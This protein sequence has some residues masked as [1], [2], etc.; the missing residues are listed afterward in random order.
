M[1]AELSM[2][3][4]QSAFEKRNERIAKKLSLTPNSPDARGRNRF[5]QEAD[6][7]ELTRSKWQNQDIPAKLDE[8]VLIPPETPVGLVPM[9]AYITKEPIIGKLVR[10]DGLRGGSRYMEHGQR[11]K[12]SLVAI[13]VTVP[14]EEGQLRKESVCFLVPID[15]FKAIPQ[16]STGNSPDIQIAA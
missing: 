8:K 14:P 5:E 16:E 13:D 11:V 4:I 6:R 10:F 9:G 3:A 1:P 7:L 2:E 12:N 15:M